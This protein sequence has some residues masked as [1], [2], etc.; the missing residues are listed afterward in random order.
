VLAGAMLALLGLGIRMALGPASPTREPDAPAGSP[1]QPAAV[2]VA[3]DEPTLP[4]ATPIPAA[5]PTLAPEFYGIRFCDRPCGPPGATGITTVAEGATSIDF[6]WSYRGMTPG[7]LY[8]RTW[9]VEGDEWLHYD[10]EWQGPSEGMM[11]AT[12]REPNGLRSGPWTLTLRISGQSA[13]DATVFV[14]G[15]HDYWDPAGYRP[16]P[17]SP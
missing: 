12:L 11:E 13:V 8:S 10:C 15:N 2:V 17:D 1:T 14:E 16:C 5:T 3:M 6:A 9:S 7:M 4:A